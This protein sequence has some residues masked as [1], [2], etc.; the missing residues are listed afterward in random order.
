MTDLRVFVP[1]AAVLALACRCA[2]AQQTPPTPPQAPAKGSV[3]EIVVKARRLNEARSRIQPSLGA[4]TTEFSSAS[5]ARIAQGSNAPLNTVLLQAPGVAEDSYGQIHVRGDHNEVQYRLDGVE[6]PEG[7]AVFGQALESRFA[8]SIAFITGALPAQY[9]QLQAAVVDITTKTGITD[10]GGSVSVYGGARDYL[11]PS[12]NYGGR[13]GDWDY[14]ITA[15]ALHSR[16]GI[17]NPTD[18][19][20]SEHDLSNQVHGLMHLSYTPDDETRFSLIAGISNAN[21]QIPNNPGQT[22]SLGLSVD[23]TSA[24]DSSN[25]TEHQREITDFGILTLQKHLGDFDVQASLFSRYSSLYFSPDPVGDLLFTGIAQTAARS[26]WSSGTQTDASWRINDSH[27]LR[28]GFQITAERTV[29]NTESNVF[30]L[31]EEGTQTTAAPVTIAQ[32]LGKTG[33]IYGLYLQDEWTLARGLTLN[34]GGRFDLVDEFTHESQ[35]SPRVNLVWQADRATTLHVGYSHYFTPPPFELIPASNFSA[36]TGTTAP[37]SC[38]VG[39]PATAPE[40]RDSTVKAEHDNYYDAGIDHVFLPGLR[41]G[42]DAYFKSARNLID[43]GQFGAPIILTA[44]N[45]AKGQVAGVEFSTS[46]DRGPWSLYANLSD[47]RAIGKDIVSSQFNFS[48]DDLAYIQ[49]HY[50]HL[51]HDEHYAGSAG[52]AFAA[53]RESDMP[54]RL[55]ADLATG[56]GLRADGNV[57]NGRALPGYY[58]INLSAT[59]SF[60]SAW[61]RGI[62]LRF[63]VLNLLDRRYEIRDGTGVGVGAPQFGLRRTLL[64]GFTQ[65]F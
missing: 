41:A 32:G 57:P 52:V 13:V 63:D 51:D 25:L 56:S 5:L 23:G 12:A 2:S 39:A 28:A 54:A 20:N 34:Y 59:Q 53:F 6:L 60:K 15:D 38:P 11:Q 8:H 49:N 55:S 9:G 58:V 37:L 4:T 17:E 14:F 33:G 42:V 40:C 27:T 50:I 35:V 21:F 29:A 44:F 18:G 48:A 62:D 64:A 3:E 46:Y 26:V 31:D 47:S 24:F 61:L 45:Y 19:F 10:P 43:E 1:A 30:D 22:P 16:V 65:N 7:L 36:F